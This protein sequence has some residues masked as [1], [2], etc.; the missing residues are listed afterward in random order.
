[1]FCPLCKAEF[2]EGFSRCSDCEIELVPSREQAETTPVELLWEGVSEVKSRRICTTLRDAGIPCNEK[3][4]VRHR[5]SL[6]VFLGLKA[7]TRASYEI[8]VFRSDLGTAQAVLER[9]D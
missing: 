3:W 2:R 8:R 6:L 4:H 5:F 9:L 1:M 7:V